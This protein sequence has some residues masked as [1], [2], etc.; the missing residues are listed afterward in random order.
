MPSSL[1]QWYTTLVVTLA[2]TSTTFTTTAFSTIPTHVGGKQTF[3]SKILNNVL[4]PS[5]LFLS[6]AGDSFPSD[7]SPDPVVDVQSE[8]YEPT[9]S[10]SLIT[11]ILSTAK[12]G[13]ISREARS[14][15]NEALLKLESFNPTENPTNSPLMNGVW[16]LKYAGGY[17]EDWALKSPTRQLALFLYSGGYSP[18]LFALRLASVIPKNVVE[19]GELEIAISREQP[20]VEAVIDVTLLG[21]GSNSVVVNARLDTVSGVR[22]TETYE[23]ATVLGQSV[24]IPQALQYSRD[25]YVTYLDE[26]LLVVRDSSGVPEILVRKQ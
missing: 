3:N 12:I 10:E 4:S 25:L 17:D 5:T 13:D 19:T 18:G 15:I 16:N 7:S 9:E 8:P 14:D 1:K 2:T 23:S 21:G 22:F 6:D 11:S 20:R 24:D 26:E